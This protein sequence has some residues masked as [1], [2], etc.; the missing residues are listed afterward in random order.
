MELLDEKRFNILKVVNFHTGL[1]IRGYEKYLSKLKFKHDIIY[2]YLFV[3][4]VLMEFYDSNIVEF[5]KYGRDKIVNI[6]EKG[7][8]IFNE[9][10][11]L[12]Q[13][14]NSE[15]VIEGEKNEQKVEGEIVAEI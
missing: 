7:K 2:S 5:K 8:L 13:M 15:Y 12:N 11:K 10:E 9:I 14:L 6:T 4:Q 1:S 3:R